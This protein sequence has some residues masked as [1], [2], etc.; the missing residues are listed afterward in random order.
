[1]KLHLTLQAEDSL[2]L[3]FP[4]ACWLYKEPPQNRVCIKYGALEE[5]KMDMHGSGRNARLYLI[6]NF[7]AQYHSLSVWFNIQVNRQLMVLF[8]LIGH[9][10]SDAH[11][12][13]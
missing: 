9:V 13:Y 6:S 3:Q 2:K 7:G 5:H 12:F 4:P 1:M 8:F 10:T 11:Y